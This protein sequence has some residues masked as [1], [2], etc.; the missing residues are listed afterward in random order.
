MSWSWWEKAVG[1]AS[2]FWICFLC[3]I[4]KIILKGLYGLMV[5]NSE[6]MKGPKRGGMFL[7]LSHLH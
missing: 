7:L 6:S 4:L 5:L 2:V 1:E 3:F